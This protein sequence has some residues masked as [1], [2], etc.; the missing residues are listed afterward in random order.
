MRFILRAV[1]IV[2]VLLLAAP[3]ASWSTVKEVTLFPDS[4]RVE[5]TAAV[6][7]QSRDSES[8][9]AVIVLPPQADP[10][11]LMVS[12]SPEGRVKID[13]IRIKSIDRIDESKVAALRAQIK[14]LQDEKKEMQARLQ[15]LDV[16]LLF[17][18]AQTK[19]KT[20]AA[21]RLN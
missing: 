2:F 15:A 6:T 13:D 12:V 3:R 10:E 21:F 14:K 17:W 7:I 4:A 11:S 20:N 5:E 18:Q 9:Q 19:A 8:A 16:Q 1:P